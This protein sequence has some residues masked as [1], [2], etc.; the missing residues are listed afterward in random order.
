MKRAEL[1]RLQ[2]ELGSESI[3]VFVCCA[4]YEER[5]LSISRNLDL[6]NIEHTIIFV[7]QDYLRVANANLAI[8]QDRVRDGHDAYTLDTGN[9][10]M[11]ADQIVSALSSILRRKD[12]KRI[13]VDITTFT[14]ESLLILFRYLYEGKQENT[15]IEFVYAVAREYSIG[16]TGK[17][18][19]LSRGNKEVRSVIGYSGILL[20]S[21]ETNL[22][23]LVGFEDLRVLTL[24]HEFEPAKVM[25]GIPDK[26]ESD[27]VRHQSINEDRLSEIKNMI[28]DVDE[29]IFRGY[30]ACSTRNSIRSIVE[31]HRRF[32]TI[33]APMN[34]KISTLG[35][36]MV[37][38]QD[39]SV[40]ICYSQANTYNV[41]NYST[42]GEYFYHFSFN[43][44]V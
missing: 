13:V 42:P 38:L 24:V 33:V 25:L 19:W 3:D 1:R 27:T 7:N 20:P 4:G 32:N 17:D 39:E 8:L 28:G 23:V 41:S 30:D 11:T 6:S 40:Q 26:S 35:A 16:Q 14:R 5:C 44:I 37:A 22:V 34:T 29:F 12:I 15:S 21:K 31:T 36:A 9:P 43:D 10:L 2:T 18:K